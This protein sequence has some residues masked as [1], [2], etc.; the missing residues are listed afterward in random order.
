MTRPT[1]AYPEHR[2]RRRR[3]RRR[4]RRISS[5]RCA[6]SHPV[7]MSDSIEMGHVR[8]YESKSHSG[9]S[10]RQMPSRPKSHAS[11]DAAVMNRMGTSQELHVRKFLPVL[12]ADPQYIDYGRP[13]E[14]LAPS[15]SSV[16]PLL[17]CRRG[18]AWQAVS[19][20]DYQMEAQRCSCGGCSSQ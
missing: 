4:S 7:V 10:I 3:R 18:R 13:R 1:T 2:R 11:S 16:F 6:Y 5:I 12:I 8:D 19:A 20:S 14:I 9:D 15:P 17:Y